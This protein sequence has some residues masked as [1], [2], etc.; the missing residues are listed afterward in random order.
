[1]D[2]SELS[3]I[4]NGF[5]QSRIIQV[6]VKLGV[7]DVIGNKGS[8]SNAIAR[9][10]GTNHRATELLLNALVALGLLNKERR[11]FYNTESSIMYLVKTSPKYFG[12]MI[13]F[14]GGLWDTWGR[15]EEAI[16]T[17]KPARSPDMFQEK[18]EETERFIMAMHTL[19][20]ARGDAEVLSNM[21]DFKGVKTIIDIGSGPGT[22]PMQFLKKYPYLRITIFDLPGTLN[23]TRRILKRE[24]MY[25]K[26][27][28]VE[29][30]YNKDEIP[31]GFD[32]AFLSNIIHSENEEAN[33]KLMKK[34]YASLNRNGRIIIKD[35]I[36][37]DTLTSPAVGAIFSI[38]MLLV[39]KGRDYSFSEVKG[40]LEDAGFRKSEWIRLK[41]PLTSSLVIGW[42]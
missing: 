5:T 21:L 2:F 12:G 13:L 30:D 41:P 14:E 31:R 25:G 42:K 35:H 18:E 38:Q 11:K 24:K 3:K 27:E 7:F 20:T 32:V 40:W 4:A 29:G 34:V 1:M 6:A 10:L 9:T 39:T 8:S 23:V 17:G 28:I 15:L 26:I 19:V 33:Q 22:Y 36:L 16:R 37:D